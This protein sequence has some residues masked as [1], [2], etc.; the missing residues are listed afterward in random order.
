MESFQKDVT[1]PPWSTRTFLKEN[2]IPLETDPLAAYGTLTEID[3]IL[4]DCIYLTGS[5]AN[6]Q[7]M[8]PSS[9]VMKRR[10]GASSPGPSSSPPR[11]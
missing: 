4:T 9:S 8:F 7:S 11:H 10:D 3:V 1:A 5:R 6:P 2:I